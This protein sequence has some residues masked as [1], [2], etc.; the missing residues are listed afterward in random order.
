MS[1][2]PSGR[3]EL[4]ELLERFE[5]LAL[6]VEAGDFEGLEAAFARHDAE[7]RALF[8]QPGPLDE[9]LARQLL[10]RQHA[11]NSQLLAQRD[12]LGAELG[13]QRREHAA[14]R[15]YLQDPDP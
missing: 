3:A 11:V 4:P 7:V 5:A 6:R 12:R 9:A 8:S 14:V 1:A 2:L 10:A 13:Q 15:L